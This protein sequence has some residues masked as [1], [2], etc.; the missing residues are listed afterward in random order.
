MGKQLPAESTSVERMEGW[1]ALLPRFRVAVYHRFAGKQ[2][3]HNS[4]WQA[5]QSSGA[6][7]EI[8]GR[9]PTGTSTCEESQPAH[10]QQVVVYTNTGKLDLAKDWFPAAL[11]QILHHT[12]CSRPPKNR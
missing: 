12:M 1:H 6:Q 4:C 5:L 2:L 10:T 7:M 3:D 9:L 11:A 8:L